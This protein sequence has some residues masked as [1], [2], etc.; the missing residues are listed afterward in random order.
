M[1]RLVVSGRL[2]RG[3]AVPSVRELARAHRVNPATVAKAYRRLVDSG[4]L[5]VRRGEGTFVGEL[6]AEALARE[7]RL[8]L[9]DGAAAFV[10]VATSV[11]ASRADAARAVRESWESESRG[12]EG[13]K[14]GG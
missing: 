11:G 4:F 10:R 6:D 9:S 14:D 12:G 13:V 5:A 2:A 8:L 3:S 1:R 7:R